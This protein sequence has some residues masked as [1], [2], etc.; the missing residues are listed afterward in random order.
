MLLRSNMHYVADLIFDDSQSKK[1]IFMHWAKC[2]VEKETTSSAVQQIQLKYSVMRRDLHN[3]FV[4]TELALFALRRS[5]PL[6]ELALKLAESEPHPARKCMVFLLAF[7]SK[8]DLDLVDKLLDFAEQSFCAG[9]VCR[10]LDTLSGLSDVP[11][12]LWMELLPK[13]TILEAF[14]LQMIRRSSNEGNQ[15]QKYF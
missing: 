6:L 14:Y 15:L 4:F 12:P 3:K 7:K 8:R 9:A 1:K 13:R 5:T 2:K 11:A 10:T